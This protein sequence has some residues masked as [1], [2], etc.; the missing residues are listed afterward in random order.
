MAI[1]N[2]LFDAGDTLVRAKSG[3][4]YIP[5][6]YESIMVRYFVTLPKEGRLDRAMAVG[7]EFLKAHHYILSEREELDQFIQYY[8]IVLR[9]CGKENLDPAAPY[10]L[11]LDMVY[12]DEK[13]VFFPD[14]FVE[15][16]KLTESGYRLGILSNTWPS[17]DRVFTRKNLRKYFDP[18]VMSSVAGYFKPDARIFEYAI[19]RTRIAAD[20]ILFID[21]FAENIEAAE[22]AGMKGLLIDRYHD[23]EKRSGNCIGD[24]TELH[25]Y[26]DRQ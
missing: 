1:K 5:P 25:A 2:I 23:C 10:E 6:N 21:D 12:N 26:L 11:A 20:Q 22:K 24:L 9:E 7:L 13:F 3:H 8:T 16:D 15:L 17:L 4:W 18:F 19:D 14:V